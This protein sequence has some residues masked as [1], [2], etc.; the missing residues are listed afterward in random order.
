MRGGKGGPPPPPAPDPTTAP[1]QQEAPDPAPEPHAAEAPGSKIPL[2]AGGGSGSPQRADK[3]SVVQAN[4]PENS[5]LNESFS[6]NN[7][8]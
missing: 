5:V 6:R 7:I 2:P 8:R 1:P 4:V 3:K